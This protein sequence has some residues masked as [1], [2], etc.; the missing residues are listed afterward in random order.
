M[1][2]NIENIET[3]YR[4]GIQINEIR[5]NLGDQGSRGLKEL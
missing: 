4:E 5:E 1:L 3:C 2:E